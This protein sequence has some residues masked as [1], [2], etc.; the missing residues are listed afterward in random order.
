[1]T[2]RQPYWFLRTIKRR[3]CLRSKP[4]LW[5]VNFFLRKHFLFFLINLHGSRP[6]EWKRPIRYVHC[7][8]R[9]WHCYRI[10]LSNFSLHHKYIY[11]FLELDTTRECPDYKDTDLVPPL[12]HCIR[13]R[14]VLWKISFTDAVRA[15]HVKI[16][17]YTECKY[18]GPLGRR[19]GRVMKVRLVRPRCFVLTMLPLKSL[20][21]WTG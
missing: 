11:F 16:S 4:T 10:N 15:G 20:A 6:S 9:L 8:G 3:S 14:F 17:Q 2:S 7:H 12:E 13:T 5:E 1:M 21:S 19:P 18:G